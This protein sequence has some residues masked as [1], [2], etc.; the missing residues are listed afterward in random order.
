MSVL[1]LIS[2]KVCCT[3]R[4]TVLLDMTGWRTPVSEDRMRS[5][6]IPELAVCHSVVVSQ[7]EET[8]REIGALAVYPR[9]VSDLPLFIMVVDILS[10]AVKK[11]ADFTAG[12]L[13]GRWSIFG[14]GSSLE[15]ERFGPSVPGRAAACCDALCSCQRLHFSRRATSAAWKTFL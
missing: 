1:V 11:C 7:V 8:M 12:A 6:L 15:S 2:R 5:R 14:Q 9:S 10:L 13:G 3:S 4:T